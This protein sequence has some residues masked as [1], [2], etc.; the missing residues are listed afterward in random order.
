MMDMR[1]QDRCAANKLRQDSGLVILVDS[2]A[3]LSK[4]LAKVQEF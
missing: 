4:K 3:Q 1:K 2:E